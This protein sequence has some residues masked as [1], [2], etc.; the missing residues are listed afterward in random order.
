MVEVGE[1][2]RLPEVGSEPMP[3]S[4]ET[5]VAFDVV[6]VRVELW[7]ELIVVGLAEKLIVGGAVV[8][9]VK[10]SDCLMIRPALSHI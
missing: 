6:Q 3:L 7:P 4:I 10:Y 8:E 9:T 5:L 2:L 1:T